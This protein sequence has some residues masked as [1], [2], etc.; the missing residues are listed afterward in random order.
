MKQSKIRVL[1]AFGTRPEIIKL[2]PVYKELLGNEEFE[3]ITA[4]T[5]Q[6][7][8]LL[9]MTLND[10]NWRVDFNFS[11]MQ[12]NQ[13]NFD[14]LNN[15]IKFFGIFLAENQFNVCI[16]HGDTTS[17][18]GI[19]LAAHALGVKVA[20]VEAGL[21]SGNL[22][23]PWPEE[24]NRRII[25]IISDFKFA[26]T[27][28]SAENLRK[29]GLEENTYVTGNTIVDMVQHTIRNHF[30][31][32]SPEIGMLSSFA[33]DNRKWILVTQHRRE[34]FGHRLESVLEALRNLADLG[35]GIIFPVHPNPNVKSVVH[36]NLSGH[37]LIHLIEPLPYSEFIFLLNRANL[38]ITDS[39]GIQEEC[40]IL[41]VPLLITREVTE[42]PEV[43]MNANVFL[44]GSDKE[45]IVELAKKLIYEKSASERNA[46]NALFG[47]GNSA[48][49]IV[50]ILL[51]NSEKSV[52]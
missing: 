17:A 5:G 9:E 19:S 27:A 1:L 49:Q 41:G 31:S 36:A 28:A 15:S 6:H 14:V 24:S 32:R 10:L 26:P 43:G 38:V 8:D 50:D 47:D 2:F 18:L 3:V 45:T 30:D 35:H 52:L 23:A 7:S 21:R 11:I 16:V 39:G 51:L 46:P 12:A 34:S 48:K 44:V 22:Q 20:H 42:R 25:D 37:P 29:E 40:A 33:K 13:N 4:T